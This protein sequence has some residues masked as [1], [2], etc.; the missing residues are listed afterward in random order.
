MDNVSKRKP[1]NHYNGYVFEKKHPMGHLVCVVGKDFGI[2]S[3]YKYLILL[4][5][6]EG[7]SKIGISFS[8]IPKAREFV[9]ADCKGD[10][11]YDWNI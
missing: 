6:A 1:H 8:S 5:R 4:E 7:E 11:G 3:E 2:E 10:S 9:K